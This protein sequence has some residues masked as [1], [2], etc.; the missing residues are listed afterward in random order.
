LPFVIQNNNDKLRDENKE[1][2]QNLIFPLWDCFTDF[3]P[4]LPPFLPLSLPFFLLS[5]IRQQV[6]SKHFGAPS[7]LVLYAH[8]WSP[9]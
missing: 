6:I 5:I 1:S 3:F 4:S 9:H 7:L 8:A 2:Q